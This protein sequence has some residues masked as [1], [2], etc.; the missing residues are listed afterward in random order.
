[1][2]HLKTFESYGSNGNVS[3]Q[4]MI[5][6]LCKYGWSKEECDNMEDYELELACDNMPMTSESASEMSREEMIDHLCN[7]CGYEYGECDMMS[8]KELEMIC[9]QTP[10]QMVAEAR[11]KKW[12]QKA[13][14]RPGALK[15]QLGKEDLT[16]SD[17]KKEISKLR[18]KDKDKTEPGIQGLS[19]TDLRKYKRLNLANTLMD[20]P[21]RKK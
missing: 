14:K 21:R 13:I 16:K 3:R 18:K 1:M 12:I 5:N 6:Q 15:K 17:I 9:R 2:K 11:G 8:D 19:K 7:N 10:M 4:E 20:L